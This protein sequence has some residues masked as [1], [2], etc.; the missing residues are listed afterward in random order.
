MR[1]RPAPATH[2]V[3]YL[4]DVIGKLSLA[5]FGQFELLVTEG[6]AC[7][8]CDGGRSARTESRDQATIAGSQL[9]LFHGNTTFLHTDAL[10]LGDLNDAVAVYEIVASLELYV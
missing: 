4:P 5:H 10:I 7:D 8:M 3:Q 1:I 9:D 2:I 6:N